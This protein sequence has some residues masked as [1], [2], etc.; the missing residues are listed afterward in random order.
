MKK[1]V[2]KKQNFYVLFVL[3]TIVLLTD[4]GIYCCLIKYKSKQKDLLPFHNSNNNY[5]LIM[6]IKNE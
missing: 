3:I 4:V 5:V 1:A 2:C 6:L